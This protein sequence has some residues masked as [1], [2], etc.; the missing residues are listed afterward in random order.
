MCLLRDGASQCCII[1]MRRLRTGRCPPGTLCVVGSREKYM[2]QVNDRRKKQRNVVSSRPEC[3]N[4]SYKTKK[5]ELDFVCNSQLFPPAAVC[6]CSFWA[7]WWTLPSNRCWRLFLVLLFPSTLPEVFTCD[8]LQLKLNPFPPQR[9]GGT[10]VLSVVFV[11][12]F[13]LEN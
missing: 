5:H 13:G 12:A 9:V 1:E 10:P 6:C 3:L 11:C 7:S 8:S 4:I 2:I